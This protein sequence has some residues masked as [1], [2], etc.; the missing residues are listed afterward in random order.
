MS[1]VEEIEKAVT[2]LK[3]TEL[4]QFRAWFDA[5]EASRFDARL[6]QDAKAGKLDRAAAQAIED[7][8][9]GR[10]REL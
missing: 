8:R 5:Y 2:A 3:P 10:A 4:A 9:K 6:E 1:T 7:Y